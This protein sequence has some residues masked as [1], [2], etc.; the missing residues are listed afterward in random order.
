LKPNEIIGHE[1][2][3]HHNKSI[4]DY[5]QVIE[6]DG[7]QIKV[8]GA[9]Q[10]QTIKD[11]WTT[12]EYNNQSSYFLSWH[13]IST[14]IQTYSP[15]LIVVTA[16]YGDEVVAM[17]LF[18][19][20]IAIRHKV[21]HSRQ[22]R[23]HQ[24]G[25]ESEDQ[26]WIE[27][28]DFISNPEHTQKATNA[29][30]KALHNSCF[31]W[32][33]IVIS[34]IR[35]ERAKQISDAFIRS[36]TAAQQPSYLTDLNALRLTKKPY[37]DSLSKNTRYQ[38]NR[39]VR[40]YESKYGPIH[41]H[42]AENKKQALAYFKEAGKYHQM[43]WQDSGYKNSDFTRFHENLIDNAFSENEVHIFKLKA[44]TQVLGILYFHIMDKTVYF[45]LQA[46]QYES[47][48]KLKPGLVA[49]SLITQ[50][51][52]DLYMN[53][54]DYMG[55]ES[56]YKDQMS[57]DITNLVTLNLKRPRLKLYIEDLA[58]LMKTKLLSRWTRG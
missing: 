24:T 39:S 9:C 46:L 53:I 29:C 34:M 55:G 4:R 17:G 57:S 38:I 45:Y 33:E 5:D 18:S 3:T 20:S 51:Y 48:N 23:L 15:D 8:N 32:D 36:A 54:Y 16:S 56:R 41:I 2:K 19:E 47:D 26:I 35:S 40:L 52:A 11:N 27:Y 44:G 22:L 42:L 14:W 13:W 43:R 10:Y 31:E 28:N 21:I 30:L 12:L 50:Y 58:R 6:I 49:H 7:Y 37:L 1:L 25:K